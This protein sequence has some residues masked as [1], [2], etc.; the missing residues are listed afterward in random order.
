[1]TS[2]LVYKKVSLAI[3]NVLYMLV[4]TKSYKKFIFINKK[5]VP[6]SGAYFVIDKKVTYIFWNKPWYF[7]S[8]NL[9]W[10]EGVQHKGYQTVH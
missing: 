3:A 2:G 4:V 7:S 5:D 9:T 1:M 10:Y 8:Q 6:S